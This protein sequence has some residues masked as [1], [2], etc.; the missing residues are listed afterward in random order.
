MM[1]IHT[2]MK[3]FIISMDTPLGGQRYARLSHEC[4]REGLDFER[5]EGVHGKKLNREMLRD[6][7]TPWCASFCTPAMVGCGLSHINLWRRIVAEQLPMALIL[8]DDAVLAPGFAEKLQSVVTTEVP[9]GWHVVLAGCFMCS[10]WVQG[11]LG[12]GWTKETSSRSIHPVSY[13]NGTHA[14]VVSLEGARYLL[15]HAPK[16]EWHIDQQ[17]GRIPGLRLYACKDPLAIQYDMTA[18]NVAENVS[19]PSVL[20]TLLGRVKDSDNIAISYYANVPIIRI[21]PYSKMHVVISP[22]TCI[23]FFLGFYFGDTLP[24][25]YLTAFVLFDMAAIPPHS[26]LDVASKVAAY[27]LG[28]AVARLF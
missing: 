17:M 16:V 9:A 14:Y 3:T 10:S 15:H 19:F 22:W 18:S 24:V 2:D 12:N 23:F 13:F 6:S 26:F 7:T 25:L 11:I 5:V 1:T 27:G 8:E 21:G 28:T 4:E 20:N